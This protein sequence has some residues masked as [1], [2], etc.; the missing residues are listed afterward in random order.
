MMYQIHQTYIITADIATGGWYLYA[1]V[2]P[3]LLLLLLG[4]EHFLGT[5]GGRLVPSVLLAGV[6]ILGFLGNFCKAIPYYTG[7]KIP[8]F[9]LKHLF[10][11]YSLEGFKQVTQQLSINMPAFITPLVI[12]I[13]ITLYFV[14]VFIALGLWWKTSDTSQP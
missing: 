10:E 5:K 2:T 9:N 3:Q 8:H 1:I 11:V 7:F 12:G 4:I 13:I 6:F 14:T